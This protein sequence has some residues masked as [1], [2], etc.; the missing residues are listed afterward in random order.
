MGAVGGDIPLATIREDDAMGKPARKPSLFD[1]DYYTWLVEQARLL[2]GDRFDELDSEHLAEELEDMGCSERRALESHL[3]NVLLHPLNW[4][5][6]PR[7]RSRS[8]PDSMANA[9]DARADLL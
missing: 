7:R 4:S 3:K 6:Q 9:R 8:W 5:A 1:H 2:R